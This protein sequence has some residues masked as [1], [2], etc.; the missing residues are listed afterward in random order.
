MMT[1]V[2][3]LQAFSRHMGIN[4]CGRQAAMAEQHLHHSQIS[5]V[6]DQMRRKRMTQGVGR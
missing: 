1:L 6:V 2:Q 4:L 5:A 3:R